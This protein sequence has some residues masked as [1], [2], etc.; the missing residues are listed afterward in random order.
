MPLSAAALFGASVSFPGIAGTASSS[1]AA[2]VRCRKRTPE[3][4]AAEN[5]KRRRNNDSQEKRARREAENEKRRQGNSS[6]KPLA[7]EA[8]AKKIKKQFDK[9]HQ[10]NPEMRTNAPRRKFK[11]NPECLSNTN[12]DEVY[13]LRYDARV[14]EPALDGARRR[15]EEAE[16]QAEAW[17]KRALEAEA[18][19]QI[20]RKHISDAKVRARIRRKMREG[21]ELSMFEGFVLRAKRTKRAREAEALESERKARADA[22]AKLAEH[23]KADARLKAWFDEIGLTE[24]LGQRGRLPTKAEVE[25]YFARPGAAEA[26][27][28]EA[29]N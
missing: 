17:K 16:A 2:P 9:R 24:L 14:H 26:S 8:R 19:D 3:Q 5:A 18:R 7:P 13:A 12:V 22:E 4:A 11:G 15:A 25:S 10:E 23:D 6:H 27:D 21:V 28:A 1:A 29:S 20:S